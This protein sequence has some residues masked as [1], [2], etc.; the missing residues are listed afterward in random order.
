MVQIQE[1]NEAALWRKLLRRSAATLFVILIAYLFVE[2]YNV[3]AGSVKVAAALCIASCV[4]FFKPW[5]SDGRDGCETVAETLLFIA[6]IIRIAYM[7]YTPWNVRVH[8]V[9]TAELEAGGGGAYILHLVTEHSLPQSNRWQFYQQPLYFLLGAL[10]S[11]VL[12]GILGTL[13]SPECIVNAAKTVSCFAACSALYGMDM[14]M[15]ICGFRGRKKCVALAFAAFIPAGIYAGGMIGVD[16]LTMLMSLLM[17]IGTL[18]WYRNPDVRHTILLALIS[19]LAVLTKIS[20]AALALYTAVVMVIVFVRSRNKASMAGKFALFAVISLP[21]GL[22]YSL[23]NYL[24]FGQS[25]LYVPVPEVTSTL[26][27]GNRSLISRILMIDFKNLLSTPYARP[28]EL[29][30]LPVYLIKS[31]LFGEYTFDNVPIQLLTLMQVTGFALAICALIRVIRNLFRDKTIVRQ[32]SAL[33]VYFLILA[34]AFFIRYPY[35]CSQD[36]RYYLIAG[37]FAAL[38]LNCG[39]NNERTAANLLITGLLTAFVPACILFFLIL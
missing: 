14:L 26:Y 17:V 38:S 10:N 32:F 27:C 31:A 25:L 13:D 7:L 1:Y 2:N 21:L 18:L 36:F 3:E 6:I 35:G 34:A 9:E 12:N 5:F 28:R 29:F 24:R 8:D 11:T 19:G 30:N 4:L 39:N 33:T 16:A 20:C 22:W 15:D 23:R 37:V